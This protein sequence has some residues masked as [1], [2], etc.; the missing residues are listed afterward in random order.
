MQIL[1]FSKHLVLIPLVYTALY[2][3]ISILMNAMTLMLVYFLQLLIRWEVILTLHLIHYGHVLFV[4]V[5]VILL[6]AAK[7]FWILLASRLRTSSFMLLSINYMAYLVS[8]ANLISAHSTAI[9][10]VPLILPN[11]LLVLVL[12]LALLVVLL[13]VLLLSVLPPSTSS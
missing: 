11:A 7:L 3:K 1:N 8:L 9:L 10:L 12:F 6:T 5:S 4:V 2:L 13:V